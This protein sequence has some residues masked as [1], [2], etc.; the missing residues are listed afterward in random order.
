MKEFLMD[1]PTGWV[2]LLIRVAKIAV[3]GFIVLQMKEWFD[4]GAFDTQATLTDA[5][6]VAGGVLVL[7]VI[8]MVLSPRLTGDKPLQRQ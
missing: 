1:S 5:L 2:D 3:V 6:F 8:Q 7:Y 4:A